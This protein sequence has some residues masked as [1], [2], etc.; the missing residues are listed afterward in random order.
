MRQGANA[1]FVLRR[2]GSS[3]MLLGCVLLAAVIAAALTAALAD[4]SAAALP[5]AVDRQLAATRDLS[6]QVS[7][8]VDAAQAAA[9]TGVVRAALRRAFGGLHARLNTAVWSDPL[10][11]PAAPGRGTPIAQVAALDGITG[12]ARL[13][14]G[15]WPGPARPGA[16]VPV[17]VPAAVAGQLDAA[18]G[19]VLAVR[20]RDT[21]A[22][23]RLRVTGWYRPRDP[24]SPYWHLDLISTSGSMVGG[25]F[26]T[27][28]PL[29][30]GRSAFGP[31]QLAVGQASWLAVPGRTRIPPA[32]LTTVAGR[33]SAA[34]GRLR[35]G[36]ALGGLQAA[37]GIPRLLTGLASSYAVARSLLAVSGLELLLVTVAAIALAARLL[38]SQ[39][40]EE[41]ALLAARG[42]A[43]SQLAVLALAE[44]LLLAAVAAV[45]GVVLGRWLAGALAGS[46]LPGGLTAGSAWAAVSV[47]LL[48]AAVVLAW[49]ALRPATPGDARAR[50]GRQAALAGAARAGGDAAVLALALVAAWQLRRYSAVGRGEPAG[51]DPVLVAA[52]ALL[53][54]GCALIPLRLAPVL[55]RLAERATARGR[56]LGGALASWEV[57]RRPVRQTGPALLAIV[58]VAIGTL[59]LAQQQSWRQSGRDQAAYAIGADVQAGPPAPLPLSRGAAISGARGVT[60]AMAVSSFNGAIGG[61]ILALDARRAA[62]TVLLR[63][64]QSPVPAAALWRTIT[65]AGRSPGLAVPGRP[66]RLAITAQLSPVPRSWGLGPLAAA[67]SVQDASGAVFSVPAGVLPADGRAHQLIA[68]LSPGRRAAYPLRLLDL[69]WSFRLPG[70]AVPPPGQGTA[71]AAAARAARQALRRRVT[72]TVGAVGTFASGRALGGWLAG[73]GSQD[74]AGGSGAVGAPPAPVSWRPGPAGRQELTFRPGFGHL[75]PAKGVPPQPVSGSV[76]LTAQPVPAVLPGI[77]TRAFLAA[78]S[79]SVGTTVPVTASG[80]PVPVRIVAAIRSFP[81]A[82]QGG[83]LLVDQAAL[84]QVLAAMSV[85]P[86]PVTS[87]WLRTA[88][89]TVPS[90]LPPGTDVAD[91]DRRAAALI[92]APV[93]AAPQR[94]A[95]AVGA[96]AAL[97]AMLGFAISVA[98]SLRERRARSALLAALGVSRAAQT[99]QLCLEQL[100]LAVPAVAGGLLLGA[101]AARLLVPAVTLT[102]LATV[103]VPP[104]AVVLPLGW[105][106]S[107]AAAVAA[108]PVLA[109]AVT[110][111]RRPDPAAELRAVELA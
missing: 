104:P 3:R 13:T 35:T 5:Q 57:A 33:I 38:A 11:V 28:G 95:A 91:R 7:G 71:G 63:A 42:A 99:V 87:W 21:G 45:A 106:V 81:T 24:A 26:R 111:A 36:Q 70:F 46:G 34:A 56:R 22:P 90:G 4:F 79:T 30:A 29:I 102:A 12:Q 1:S 109:A 89:G 78:S 83:V 65:P 32:E 62:A 84:Q 14:S 110:V 72:L 76:T 82:G 9:D 15:A 51:I 86:V 44:A 41:A 10:G 96:A 39:R 103:P 18:V 52:P 68:Q 50:R 55:V 6:V 23:I 64:D 37:T 74:L 48:V 17:A 92:S 101:V 107:L 20:D 93:A 60:A 75:V 2:M 25:G 85:P 16:P 108:L 67:V 58:A 61:E 100:L 66:A 105:A 27:Y 19:H 40:E 8:S 43:R 94:A 47:V 54:A 88:G 69:A 77:A 49:P 98:A 80:S 97:L 59:A 73:A 53:L 31:R